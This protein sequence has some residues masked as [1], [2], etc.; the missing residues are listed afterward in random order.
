MM[1][2]RW[3]GALAIAT[4][5]LVLA[6][7]AAQAVATAVTIAT[8]GHVSHPV[9]YHDG[10]AVQVKS[11]V[12]MAWNTNHGAVE[13]R[14]WNRTTGSW[15]GAARQISVA[16]LD[17]G[18][19][20]GTGTNP[21][22][23]DVPTLYADPAGRVY[24][25]YGGGTA[26]KTLPT[27]PYFRAGAALNSVATWGP[28]QSLPVPGAAYDFEAL[29]NNKGVNEII[30][31]QGDNPA[32][33]GSLVYLRFLP[34]TASAPG[35]FEEPYRILVKGG[36]D[37]TACAW[38]PTPGCDI[39]V[40]GRVALGPPD[41]S[42]PAAPSPIYVTWGWSEMNLSG[43]CGDPGGFC[44]RGVY[45]AVSYDGGDTFEN[46]AGT[47][48]TD[49]ASGPIAYD[50][51]H[52]QVVNPSVD[53]G[54]FKAIAVPGAY[55]GT[56]WIAYQPGADQKAGTIVVTHPSGSGWVAQTVDA[57]RAWNNHLVMR[58]GKTGTRLYL[59]SDIAQS[60]SN[61]SNLYQWVGSTSGASW[62]RSTLVVGGNWYLTG[63]A[64][65]TA[66]FLA[67]RVPQSTTATTVAFTIVPVP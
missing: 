54:L 7:S 61:A 65:T 39:F 32:G 13:A 46:V 6:P 62:T 64:I 20:D 18:C 40:I 44:D 16:T 14:T 36:Y 1:K 50:D 22:R 10:V 66:E 25:L 4:A 60:G 19:V 52:Y 37:A 48:T 29:R 42:N 51:P 55:P 5:V 28:E 9:W 34:G 3:P 53:V 49:L 67:W 33:A 2:L 47:A 45:A 24:A 17:C 57:S 41:P 26:S 38:L 27:G 15:V 21:N 35:V 23:H 63:R 58:L 56:P 31:Q 11:L 30:G 59:W 8:D 12:H 43:T